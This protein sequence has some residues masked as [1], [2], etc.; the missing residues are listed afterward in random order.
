[1]IVE[2][3]LIVV[4]R[5]AAGATPK[6]TVSDRE[7]IF[8]P[9]HKLSCLLVFRATQPSTESNMS[10]NIMNIAAISKL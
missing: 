4:Y 8:F 6:E 9:N 2:V 5:N 1:M 7:S 3:V 10:A